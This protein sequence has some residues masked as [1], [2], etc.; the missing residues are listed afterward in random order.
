MRHSSNSDPAPALLLGVCLGLWFFFKGFRVL[1]EYRVLDDTPRMPIR[2]VPMGFVHLRGKA[3]ASELVD[4]PVSHTP[5]CFYRVE[6]DQWKSR[7]KGHDW[8]HICTDVNG[9][10]FHIADE[11][12]RILIDAHAAEYDLPV[13]AERKVNSAAQPILADDAKLLEYVTQAQTHSMTDRMAQWVD[14]RFDKAHA[15][16]NPEL[17]AKRQAFRE[18]FDGVAGAQQGG[19]LPF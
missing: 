13:T 8:I 11:T 14:K 2:S 12:G 6:I 17:Q 15:E 5:C 18:I 4:S 3:D 7:N 9:Y 1:R 16:D 19:K 10:Q